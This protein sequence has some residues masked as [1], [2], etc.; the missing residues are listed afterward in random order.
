MSE[1]YKFWCK[2]SIRILLLLLVIPLLFG[3][4]YFFDL[5]YMIEDGEMADNVLAY[6]AQMQLLIKNIYFLAVIFISCDVFSGEIENG[7]IRISMVHMYS[8]K[9]L[10]MEKYLSL[11]G[12]IT[13]F[14][15]FFWAVNALIYCLC[16]QKINMPILICDRNVM[17]YI[18]I[19]VGYLESFFLCIAL[20][21]CTGL[22]LKKMHNVVLIY[23]LW[24]SLR[25]MEEVI[26]L[27]DIVVE[28]TADYLT[29]TASALSVG[30]NIFFLNGLMG[31]IFVLLGICVFQHKDM[32]K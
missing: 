12:V 7:Q 9:K 31:V 8:R 23:I 28:F 20:A 27:K 16:M 6:C 3:V 21:F 15:C 2:K 10:M 5:S 14:H 4:G 18:Q 1:L 19:F 29:E 24:F 11:C 26:G 17:V 13:M 32:K 25:Y 30:W 22:F